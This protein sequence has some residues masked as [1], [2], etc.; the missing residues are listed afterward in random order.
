MTVKIIN[1][2]YLYPCK[3]DSHHCISI[4]YDGGYVT[5]PAGNIVSSDSEQ[6]IEDV[7]FEL[8]SYGDIEITEK[9]EGKDLLNY[10]QAHFPIK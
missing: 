6:V 10:V 7:I 9:I 4:G 8:Q 5:S 3:V 2:I 1:A